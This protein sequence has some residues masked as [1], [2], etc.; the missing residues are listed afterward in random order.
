[1]LACF[2]PNSGTRGLMQKPH[3]ANR[4]LAAIADCEFRGR[5][6]GF[7]GLRGGGLGTVAAAGWWWRAT[8]PRPRL[9]RSLNPPVRPLALA[10]LRSTRCHV[11]KRRLHTPHL[12]NAQRL[13]KKAQTIIYLSAHYNAVFDE[14][15]NC[16]L[17]GYRTSL[18]F[19]QQ[20]HS[21]LVTK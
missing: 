11:W 7:V 3:M 5:G 13:Q 18:V 2:L 16:L 10:G 8:V 21:P 12:P 20:L 19:L 15:F 9:A 6:C 14:I 17:K 1:M 4:A